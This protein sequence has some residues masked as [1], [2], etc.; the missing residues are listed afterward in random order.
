ML[1]EHVAEF[2]AR[3][4]PCIVCDCP[5]AGGFGLWVVGDAFGRKIG[6]PDGRTRSYLYSICADCRGR[7]AGGDRWTREFIEAAII[8]RER[9]ESMVALGPDGM[10]I[11]NPGD[12]PLPA[13]TVI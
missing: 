5:E 2:V 7:A 1:R 8:A 12:R 9:G 4:E 6:V 13:G 11:V 10:P 3:R